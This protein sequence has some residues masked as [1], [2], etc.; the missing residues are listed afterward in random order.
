MASAEPV[1]LSTRQRIIATAGYSMSMIGLGMVM[2][3]HGPTLPGLTARLGLESEASLS[4]LLTAH[5]LGYMLGTLGYGW[6]LDHYHAHAHRLVL[7]AMV[8]MGAGAAL[9]PLA[10][11]LPLVWLCALVQSIGGGGADIALNIAQVEVW[12]GANGVQVEGSARGRD[13][14]SSQL[15]S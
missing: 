14:L 15:P 12:T 1:A 5:G 8:T 4:P 10:G 7:A 2:T 9:V 11:S 3:L 13:L 6:L